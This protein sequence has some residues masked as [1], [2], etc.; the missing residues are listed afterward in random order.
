MK[1]YERVGASLLR[2]PYAWLALTLV[3]LIAFVAL[4]GLP[5]LDEQGSA[6]WMGWVAVG[7]IVYTVGTA[8][9]LAS[10]KM[11]SRARERMTDDRYAVVRWVTGVS[12]ALFGVAGTAGNGEGWPLALGL[13]ASACLLTLF[14]RQLASE[15]AA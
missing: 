6:A 10:D 11:A 2:A 9:F 13:L 5:L 4:A 3:F 14:A 15:L 7:L 8:L 1:S 12:P